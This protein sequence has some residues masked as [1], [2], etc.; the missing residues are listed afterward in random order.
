MLYLRIS[1][2]TVN[3]EWKTG[4][5]HTCRCYACLDMSWILGVRPFG[6]L[7]LVVGFHDK[8]PQPYQ[9]IFLLDTLDNDINSFSM[10]VSSF[11]LKNAQLMLGV[12]DFVNMYNHLVGSHKICFSDCPVLR[13]CSMRETLEKHLKSNGYLHIG[14]AKTMFIDFGLPKERGGCC[15]LRY[16]DT[17]P[18]AKKKD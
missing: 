10:R 3:Q 15:Y 6:V 14:H 13:P 7:L 11:T 9:A 1:S 5:Y 2:E 18:K 17:N 4:S 8:G 16:D 12:K